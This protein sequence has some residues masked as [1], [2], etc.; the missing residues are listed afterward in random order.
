ML[1]STLV[2]GLCALSVS[3]FADGLNYTFVQASY[4]QVQFDDTL[5]DVDGDGFAVNGS[6]AVADNFHLF[7]EYQ[8]AGLDFG[9]D[10]NLLEAGLGY[11]TPIS[12]KMD[13][14]GRVSYI[15]VEAEA[16]GVPSADDNGFAVGL[17][18][19]GAMSDKFELNGGLD[20]VDVGDSGSETR[21]N[22][23]FMYNITDSFTVGVKGTWW[24]DVNI[25]QLGGRFYF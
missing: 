18:L 17:G 22:I 19:R 9:V 1:R 25:Y 12:D 11:N 13:I 14:I 4:G 10:L 8:M 24:E 6:V 16:P 7:G 2:I 5:I 21:F 20:Y 15:N 3:A 23:G